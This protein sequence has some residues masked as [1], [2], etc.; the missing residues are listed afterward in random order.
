M[1]GWEDRAT[2]DPDR[3]HRYWAHGARNNLG[4]VTG[5]SGLVVIDLDD[6]H[7]GR[8]P[9]RFM[10]AR[11]GRDVLALLAARAGEEVPTDTYTVAT[12]S[13]FHLYFRTPTGLA[14]RNTTAKL[15]WRIDT[16][17]HGGYVVAASS[18]VRNGNYRVVRA[19][20]AA[21]LPGWL[22]EALT[23]PAPPDPGPPLWLPGT[24][25]AAYVSAIVDSEARAV[26]AAEVGTRHMI[27]LKAART[28]G[29]LVGGGELTEQDARNALI[30]ASAPHV[31]IAGYTTG[32]VV[33]TIDDAIAY[34]KRLP[35]RIRPNI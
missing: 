2:T 9:K 15:G 5:K 20:P 26:T 17:A 13:G 28:L 32:E 11:H 27:L 25:A 8:A 34:G 19:E 4:I 12:P 14:L 21:E 16:R 35:R 24:R 29:R 7:D 23:P 1:R 10:G 3:I 30:A 31:G 22:A 6:G 18:I 33:R